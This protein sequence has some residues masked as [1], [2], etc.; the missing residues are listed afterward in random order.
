MPGGIPCAN[1]WDLYI[2]SDANSSPKLSSAGGSSR[3]GAGL[4]KMRGSVV[5]TLVT[6]I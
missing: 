4:G 3:V 6:R 5:T 2:L 1:Q